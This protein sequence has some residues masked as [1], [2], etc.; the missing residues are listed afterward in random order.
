MLAKFFSH[1]KEKSLMSD[2]LLIVTTVNIFEEKRALEAG[3][4]VAMSLKKS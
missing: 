4:T 3:R 1:G 2:W